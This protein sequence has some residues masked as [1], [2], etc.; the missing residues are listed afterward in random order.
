VGAYEHRPQVHEFPVGRYGDRQPLEERRLI[1]LVQR[2]D[3]S[4]FPLEGTIENKSPV[5]DLDGVEAGVDLTLRV[6][7]SDDR[8][9]ADP[10][11][12][13]ATGTFTFTG[14]PS[15][16]HT[17]TVDDGTIAPVFEF[18]N[19][20]AVGA[21]NI[22]VVIGATSLDSAVNLA[23]AINDF[24]SGAMRHLQIEATVDNTGANPVV[25]VKHRLPGAVGNNAISDTSPAITSA[26]M[27]GGADASLV[28]FRVNGVN[29]TSL[30]VKPGARVPF[31]IEAP[32]EEF[33]RFDTDEETAVGRLILTTNH[34][35]VTS[36]QRAVSV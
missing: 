34:I 3:V 30:V 29:V 24:G 2:D 12:V 1:A 16:G 10:F 9:D 7:E 14:N 4:R 33:L 20:G 11:F 23:R 18:D 17:V 26:G 21:G 19:T 27:A 22:R 32:T 8:G 5:G 31:I 25:Q 35:K 15:D 6:R 36:W 28:T 13:H